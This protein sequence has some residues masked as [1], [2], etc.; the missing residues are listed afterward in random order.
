M[1]AGDKLSTKC[2]FDKRLTIYL[3]RTKTW[4]FSQN[5]GDRYSVSGSWILITPLLTRTAGLPFFLFFFL[6][7]MAYATEKRTKNNQIV[8]EE[9]GRD[10]LVVAIVMSSRSEANHFN[11]ATQYVVFSVDLLSIQSLSSFLHWS[12]WWKDKH[13]LN[14]RRSCK[15]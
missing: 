15:N 8:S 14:V 13:R 11:S 3:E 1:S 4:V 6:Q 5:M 7:V 9:K 10:L 12:S 2:S